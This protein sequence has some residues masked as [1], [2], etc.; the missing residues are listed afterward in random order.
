MLSVMILMRFSLIFGRS[1]LV[2]LGDLTTYDSV[3]RF[4]I[5]NQFKDDYFTHALSR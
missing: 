4:F 1:A 2:N 5:N 3:K